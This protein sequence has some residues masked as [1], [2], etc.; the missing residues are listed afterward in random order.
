MDAKRFKRRTHETEECICQWLL[1]NI[2]I[3]RKYYLFRKV[4]VHVITK[5][6]L[7]SHCEMW[8]FRNTAF[9]IAYVSYLGEM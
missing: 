9:F 3:Q 8:S 7:Y 6:D 5:I 4:H 1:Q 2:F